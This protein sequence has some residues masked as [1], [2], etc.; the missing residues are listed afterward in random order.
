[1]PISTQRVNLLFLMA[2]Q[3]PDGLTS[4]YP[5]TGHPPDSEAFVGMLHGQDRSVVVQPLRA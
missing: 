5:W 2:H 3:C 4:T 1:M